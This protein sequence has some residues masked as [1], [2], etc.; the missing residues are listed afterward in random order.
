MATIINTTS[1]RDLLRPGLAA[2]VTA[3]KS[4]PDQWSEIFTKHTSDKE[5]EIEVELKSLGLAQIK[6][7]GASLAYDSMNQTYQTTYVNRYVAIGFIITRQAIKD[8]LY[9][10]SFPMQAEALKRSLKITKEILGA[11][12]LNNGFDTNFPIGDGQPVYSTAHPLSGGPGS[13]ANTFS[14]QVDLSEASLEQMIIGAQKFRDAAGLLE[15]NKP[16]KLIVPRELQ[17]TAERILKSSFR[18]STAN[19]DISAVYN[20]SSVP[21]GYRVNQYLTDTNAYFLLTDALNGFKYYEREPVETDMYEDFDTDSLKAKALER[22]SFGI[23]N[24][25]ATFGS[26]GS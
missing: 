10:K 15:N 4:Y 21:Q 23:T 12:I 7:E 17:F 22:Y 14:V 18:T 19:N 3:G 25:R 5:R 1:I 13:I 9:Q 26:S 16:M 2:I 20:L 24:W 11:S 8:N 6:A